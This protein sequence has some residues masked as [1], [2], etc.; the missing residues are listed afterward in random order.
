MSTPFGNQDSIQ[1]PAARKCFVGD[2]SLNRRARHKGIERGPRSTRHNA[3]TL[4]LDRSGAAQEGSQNWQHRTTLWRV[5]TRL[6][7]ELLLH[8]TGSRI[9]RDLFSPR[10][11]WQSR[12]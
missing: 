2:A 9:E 3:T 12:D 6:F 8:Q 1:P 4:D 11:P 7:V 10:V 5:R